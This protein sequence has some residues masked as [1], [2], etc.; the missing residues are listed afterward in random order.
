MEGSVLP[1][2]FV[3]HGAVR[4]PDGSPVPRAIVAAAD[5]GLRSET[6]LGRATTGPDGEYAI[7][8]RPDQLRPEGKRAADL[9]VRASD[10]AGTELARSTLLCGAPADVTVDLV[11]GNRALRGQAEYDDA[12]SRI[13]PYLAD[14]A[15]ADLER[16][17]VQFLSCSTGL[18][19][20]R[21]A[22]LIVSDRLAGETSLPAWLFYALG[23]RGVRLQLET[24]ALLR[25]E[26]LK[27]ALNAAVTANIVSEPGENTIDRL[28]EQL[29][30]VIVRV[31]SDRSRSGFSV[32]AVLA[33]SLATREQQEA[34][35]ASYVNRPASLDDF[36]NG[37]EGDTRFSRETVE[38]FRLTLL[39]AALTRYR[40][41][42]LD[43]LKR[44]RQNGEV[45]SLRDLATLNRARW[46]DIV[47]AAAAAG[48][49]ELPADVP[50]ET[51]DDR[52]EHYLTSLRA[53]IESLLPSD[54]IRRAL[55]AAEETDDHLRL[56]L[57]NTPDLDLYWT[58]IDSYLGEHRETA[59]S[60]IAASAHEAVIARARRTQRL[61]RLT[62]R[63]DQ[64]RVLDAAGFDSAVAIART[65]RRR[66]RQRFIDTV[67]QMKD[68][69]ED[70][71]EATT[72]LTDEEGTK[73]TTRTLLMMNSAAA[74]DLV[75]DAIHNA[76]TSKTAAYLAQYANLKSGLD[77]WPSGAG[78]TEDQQKQVKAAAF[79]AIPDLE[80]LFGSQSFCECEQCRSVYSPAAYLVDLLHQLDDLAKKNDGTLKYVDAASAPAPIAVFVDRR[81]DIALI[82]LTCE[83]TNT[84]LPYIDLVNEA[85]ESY[86]DSHLDANDQWTA[87]AATPTIKVHDTG[88][89][90]AEELRAVPQYVVPRV[91]KAIAR[92][93]VYP[94]TLPFDRSLEV[95]RAYLNHLGTSRA[96]IVE[97]FR[98]GALTA[99]S[100]VALTIERLGMCAK[101]YQVI[102]GGTSIGWPF[103]ATGG[104]ATVWA[105]YGYG[106]AAELGGL[107]AV[108]ELLR[109]TGLQIDELIAVLKT[110][111]INPSINSGPPG[112]AI[113]IEF[114][115]QPGDDACD[116]SAM[117]LANVPGGAAGTT[118]FD[119]LQRFL[120]LWRA[121]GW[122]VADV[123]RALT[124]FKTLDDPGLQKLA[125]VK[126]LAATLDQ[127]V[128]SLLPL[129]ADLDTWSVDTDESFYVKVFLNRS[130]VLDDKTRQVFEQAQSG[131]TG[132]LADH[133]SGIAA[134][135]AITADDVEC[136][137][138]HAG[139]VADDAPVTVSALSMIYR[140]GTLSKALDI[141]VRDLITLLRLV[142]AS[143]HPF[144]PGDP[145]PAVRFVERAG[146]VAASEFAVPL[147]N[148]LFRNEAEPTRHPAPTRAFVK[149]TLET[150]Q[151]GLA[152]IHQELIATEQPPA[153]VLR[154]RLEAAAKLLDKP[155]TIPDDIDKTLAVL[156]PRQTS[157]DGKPLTVQDRT[158]F[159]NDHF[160]TYFPGPAA[161]LFGPP[162][163]GPQDQQAEQRF[164]DDVKTVLDALVPWLRRKLQE[165]H[166]VQTITDAM[167]TDQAVTQRLLKNT[168]D[169]TQIASPSQPVL[170]Y[171]LNLVDANGAPVGLD[172]DKEPPQP[173]TLVIQ[174]VFKAAAYA[175]AF[176]MTEPEL[177]L[178]TDGSVSPLRDDA[179]TAT[180]VLKL[181]DLPIIGVAPAGTQPG[182]LFDVWRA[183]RAFYELRDALP[184]SEKTLVDYFRAADAD[185]AAVLQEATGFDTAKAAT[186]NTGLGG[187]APSGTVPQL[188]RLHR[189][190]TFMKRVGATPAEMFGWAAVTPDYQQA[191]A[192]VQTV[193]ARYERSQWLE[194]ARGLND[195]L[196]ERQRDALVAFLLPRLQPQIP[197]GT[198]PHSL[199]N[200]GSSGPAV[201]ELQQ[202]LNMSQAGTALVVDGQ[203]GPKT[204]AAVVAFQQASGLTPDGKVGPNTWAA[205]DR[206]VTTPRSAD[207][208][209]DYFLIDVQMNSR[210][211]TSRI[212]QAISSVQLFVQRCLLNLEPAVSPDEIDPDRWEWMKHYRIWEANRKVFLYPETYIVPELRD[213]KTPFFKEL[214]TEL[215]QNELTDATI[216]TAFSNYLRKLDEVARLD[217]RAFCRQS[218]DGDEIY[219]VF[220]RTWNPPYTYYYRRG[221]YRQGADAGEWTAWERIDLDIDS[222]YLIPIVV[223]R[224][225][226]L[227]WVIAE[228]KDD[229]TAPTEIPLP[230]T[231][232]TIDTSE[233]TE[234][235]DPPRLWEFRLASSEYFDGRWRNIQKSTA[236]LASKYVIPTVV[237]FP[238]PAILLPPLD[239]HAFRVESGEDDVQVDLY[240]TTPPNI[241]NLG[242]GV[243]PV[244]T[245]TR[246]ACNGSWE[247]S[248]GAAAAPPAGPADTDIFY[249]AFRSSESAT[250]LRI[251]A[252]QDPPTLAK[253]PSRYI[254]LPSL[255]VDATTGL[256][257]FFFGDRSQ[258]YFARHV[259]EWAEQGMSVQ[260]Q[261]GS[262]TT[263]NIIETT[264]KVQLEPDPDQFG[265]YSVLVLST[266]E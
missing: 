58:N 157:L 12:V 92:N 34:F 166:V 224:R 230:G 9:I 169:T 155:L 250:G 251:S 238:V 150:V 219:H 70:V 36:W 54:S 263:I 19:R 86:I 179:G 265:H 149:T 57:N 49:F 91:Y 17:D 41:P 152:A 187:T 228:Q 81:P 260:E 199:L 126:M 25:R 59:L 75:A 182:E 121:L 137:R 215:L 6:V 96:E 236:S 233:L 140:Y 106:S 254:V 32:G 204:Y 188:V 11:V 43:Q 148:Y 60:G 88:K 234:G 136:I 194:I 16:N 201:K 110:R 177:K 207:E 151:K 262:G 7:H 142:P 183:L 111:F 50:G 87:S 165:S 195:P 101:Q 241:A 168:L 170:D 112:T 221:S 117:K 26:M 135:L 99:A 128:A 48:G 89:V 30:A 123:D 122:D 66:F 191:E 108:P 146:S 244:G 105:G 138:S 3:V 257:P 253:T 216:E 53:S 217:I 252:N 18:D 85:L 184:R 214:E 65:P 245:F 15:F 1:R 249:M 69:L 23:R 104:G 93:G 139:L 94:M 196:R 211:L 109:R 116:V 220:G 46:R 129:W 247:A 193:K 64:V 113:A 78:G 205:L 229:R 29:Q 115:S 222:E 161:T 176:A 68:T 10:E 185:K 190:M 24:M 192:I 2:T 107:I 206:L 124:A 127:P 225:L 189:A 51:P 261:P 227:F 14:T 210:M 100:D 223:E 90:P 62:G 202:K 209:L 8:Y 102:T 243:S 156:D 246:N 154:T 256:Y 258:T 98:S 95:V 56:F 103:D 33:A 208:L 84:T 74:G 38:D 237:L 52:L 171:L 186:V 131:A 239:Q 240:R 28:L 72:T 40:V 153:D 173:P 35:L 232:K 167:A 203:F 83:N 231:D 212:K 235:G 44:L 118:C 97:A 144:A 31:A 4:H 20:L 145:R 13:Q 27:D 159:V 213:D 55:T 180:L 242:G 147:L 198:L 76:A 248:G 47:R 264:N 197:V 130:V 63:A 132:H 22:T 73:S 120:R 163:P 21:I 259:V 125:A 77:L 160:A 37:L 200:Q 79:K 162:L 82:P 67:E 226:Y 174:R 114:P 134:A 181:N 143:M 119:H 42:V 164:L 133:V 158:N 218:T 61:L 172:L 175:N 80:T 255:E 39:L 141:R 45:R 178:F 71:F 5:V 266:T